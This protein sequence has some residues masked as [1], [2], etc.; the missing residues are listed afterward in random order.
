MK[1]NHV[2][3]LLVAI[4]L[5]YAVHACAITER[6]FHFEFGMLDP[7]KDVEILNWRYGDS[8]LP[9]THASKVYLGTGHIPQA[10]NTGGPFPPGDVLYVKWRVLSTGKVHEDTA[11]LHNSL[12]WN[13][14][15][16]IIHFAVKGP[17]LYVYL[18]Q[19][20]DSKEQLHA[21]GAPDCPTKLYKDFKC[22]RIYPD[23]WQN[24]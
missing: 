23:H 18:I 5:L 20:I 1:K 3:V 22:S 16:K 21:P 4:M 13:M 10:D 2:F 19:G 7:N 14:N 12:P 9:Y 17:Q 6:D 8:K 11:D 15:G 24:F